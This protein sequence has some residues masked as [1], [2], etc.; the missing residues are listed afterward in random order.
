MISSALLSPLITHLISLSNSPPNSLF[1]PAE[2]CSPNASQL[3]ANKF[4]QFLIT[5]FLCLFMVQFVQI[6]TFQTES[7][8]SKYY[9]RL[10]LPL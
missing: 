1:V 8:S 10:W 4:L 9:V 2:G 6:S 3:M 5:I 7:E